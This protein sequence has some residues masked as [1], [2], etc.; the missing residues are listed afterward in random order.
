MFG[1]FIAPYVRN[2]NL[3]WPINKRFTPCENRGNTV[4]NNKQLCPNRWSQ[5]KKQKTGNVVLSKQKKECEA[6]QKEKSQNQ[7]L[8]QKKQSEI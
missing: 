6:Q 4:K 3:Y 1:G 7:V 8:V 2:S 5:N